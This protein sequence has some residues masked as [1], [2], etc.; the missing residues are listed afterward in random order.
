MPATLLGMRR[1]SNTKT[2]YE[3][4]TF[5]AYLR[6]HFLCAAASDRPCYFRPRACSYTLDLTRPLQQTL[7]IHPPSGAGAGVA[8]EC[9]HGPLNQP[10]DAVTW[11]HFL[12]CAGSGYFAVAECARRSELRAA[13]VD[14]AWL[15][16]VIHGSFQVCARRG[17]RIGRWRTR[18]TQQRTLTKFYTRSLTLTLIGRRCRH[19]AG[20]RYLKRGVSAAVRATGPCACMALSR[21]V[22]QGWCANDVEVEQILDD[23]HGGFAS[24]VQVR[25]P[26][27]CAVL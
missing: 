15:V 6:M 26:I 22:A 14:G 10:N 23:H 4:A 17:S 25:R 27:S 21:I 11:N 2:S 3:T 13:G 5:R 8:T 20:T 1:C 16:P 24:Y 18:V 9:H 7:V 19:F 12:R